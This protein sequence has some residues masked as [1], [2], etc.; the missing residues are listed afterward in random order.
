MILINLLPQ[1][2]R[3]KSRTPL[4]YTVGICLAVA[5][6]CTLLAWWGW[7]A[8]GVRA[9]IDGELAV[10]RDTMDSISPQ[11]AYHRSLESESKLYK[12]REATLLEITKNRMSWTRKIDQLVDVVN[13]GGDGEKYLIWFGNL[14]VEQTT[15]ARRNTFGGLKASGH[16]G[17]A[18]F[19]HVANFLEDIE[20]SPFAADF[21]PPAPPEGSQSKV[22]TDLMP[23]EVWSFPLELNLLGPDERGKKAAEQPVAADGDDGGDQ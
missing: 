12:S 14:S 8:F 17:N 7:L 6:N 5:A 10:L 22:D 3:R 21:L 2:Y 1:E 4:K 19:A 15:D 18:N 16:S 9:E 20:R 23:A 11:I 13:K